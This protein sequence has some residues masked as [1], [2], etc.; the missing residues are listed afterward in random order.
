MNGPIAG[1]FFH[2]LLSLNRMFSTLGVSLH[3]LER[4]YYALVTAQLV[5]NVPRLRSPFKRS[6]VVHLRRFGTLEFKHQPLASAASLKLLILFWPISPPLA[7]S[8]RGT[9]EDHLFSV[10]F[11]SGCLMLSSELRAI[12]SGCPLSKIKELQS[13]TGQSR[14]KELLP[15]D[16]QPSPRHL[17]SQHHVDIF[18]SNTE[19]YT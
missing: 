6:P 18:I 12:G 13:P 11:V 8:V 1:Y 5:I 14:S 7:D 19:T 3:S 2:R 16:T 17:I 9:E 10:T 4:K 15:P